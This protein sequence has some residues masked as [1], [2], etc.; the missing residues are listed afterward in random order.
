MLEKMMKN[1]KNLS[2]LSQSNRQNQW[3]PEQWR[4]YLV[5]NA[6]TASERIEIGA[7]FTREINDTNELD[8]PTLRSKTR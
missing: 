3:T 8:S 1:I 4:S 7:I 2:R 6:S 5:K